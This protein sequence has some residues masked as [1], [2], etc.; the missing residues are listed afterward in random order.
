MS[1]RMHVSFLGS[2]VSPAPAGDAAGADGEAVPGELAGEAASDPA[3]PVPPKKAK[4]PAHSKKSAP[5]D[6]DGQG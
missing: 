4:D 3:P 6:E 5:K 2:P 1:F